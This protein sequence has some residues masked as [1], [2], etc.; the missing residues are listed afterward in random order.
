MDAEF[1]HS[2]AVPVE[3]VVASGSGSGLSSADELSGDDAADDGASTDASHA[4]VARPPLLLSWT[5]LPASASSATAVSPRADHSATVWESGAAL[6]V[7]G[8]VSGRSA[9]TELRARAS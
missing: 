1:D 6:L 7:F 2:E 3:P 5:Q 8:G 4:G 9:I